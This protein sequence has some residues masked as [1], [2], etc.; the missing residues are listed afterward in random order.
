VLDRL[1]RCAADPRVRVIAVIGIGGLGK[2]ALVGHWLKGRG[3]GRQVRGLFG[4]S[5]KANRSVADFRRTLAEF[6]VRRDADPVPA[7]LVVVLDALEVLQQAPGDL[8][9]SAAGPSTVSSWTTTCA[10]F[11]MPS[12]GW[13]TGACVLTSRFPFADLAALEALDDAADALTLARASG[14]AWAERDALHLKADS[15]A[16]WSRPTSTSRSGRTGAHLSRQ[17]PAG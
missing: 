8:A 10:P 12:A 9:A 13:S 11:S 1:S 5:F 2:T 14:Y 3:A 4:W 15:L 6:A 17:Y 7:P 16:A